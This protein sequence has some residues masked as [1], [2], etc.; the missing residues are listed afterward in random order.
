[1]RKQKAVNAERILILS[2]WPLRGAGEEHIGF[3][4]SRNYLFY[5][6]LMTPFSIIMD[7]FILPRLRPLL[8]PQARPAVFVRERPALYQVMRVGL[9][10]PLIIMILFIPAA[11]RTGFYIL[12]EQGT[13]K[14][15][16]RKWFP[17]FLKWRMGVSRKQFLAQA[18]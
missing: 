18:S 7:W 8:S 16:L 10:F 4:I 2:Y 17:P 3:G 12:D 5:Q 15:F 1:M 14:V 6:L 11:R 13:A 9:L